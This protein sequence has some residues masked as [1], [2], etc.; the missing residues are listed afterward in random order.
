M[1]W[2]WN[3]TVF[4]GRLREEK[5]EAGEMEGAGEEVGIDLSG[6]CQGDSDWSHCQMLHTVSLQKQ[7][8]ATEHQRKGTGENRGLEY[9]ILSGPV[10]GM[11]SF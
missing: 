4:L 9:R 7:Q 10:E 6:N 3:K 1:I 5:I 11:R 8:G 2:L